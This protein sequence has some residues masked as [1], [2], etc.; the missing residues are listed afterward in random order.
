MFQHVPARIAI[1]APALGRV[2]TL[3]APAARSA[4]VWN[5]WPAKTARLSQMAPDD[6]RHFVCVETANCKEL[7]LEI[8]PGTSHTLALELSVRDL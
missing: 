1:H 8:A 3:H 7:G 5:P 4:I 2:V 6:W